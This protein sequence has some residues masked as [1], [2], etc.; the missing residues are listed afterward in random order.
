VNARFGSQFQASGK[1]LARCIGKSPAAALRTIL[2]GRMARAPERAATV[3]GT[4]TNPTAALSEA[5]GTIA[6][7]MG[8]A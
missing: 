5:V 4:K 1:E 3:V 8:S 2:V 7:P 6:K